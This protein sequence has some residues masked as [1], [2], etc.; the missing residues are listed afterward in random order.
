MATCG[1]QFEVL[2]QLNLHV[3]DASGQVRVAL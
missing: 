2:T 1:S 3:E